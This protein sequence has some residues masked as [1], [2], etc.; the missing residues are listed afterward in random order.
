MT[1]W[2]GESASRLTSTKLA[3]S[4]H[5]ARGLVFVNQEDRMTKAITT[6][7]LVNWTRQTSPVNRFVA[8][9]LGGGQSPLASHPLERFFAPNFDSVSLVVTH[10]SLMT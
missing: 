7:W 8:P 2:Q 10:R 4:R 5:F 9:D 3:S 1:A 6:D